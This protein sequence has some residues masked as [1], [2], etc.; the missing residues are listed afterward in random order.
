MTAQRT[1]PVATARDVRVKAREI[2]AGHRRAITWMLALH[3][4]A[5]LAA[6]VG[7]FLLGSIVQSVKDGTTTGH[8]DRL[9]E[10]LAV[11]LTAQTVFTFD[12][13]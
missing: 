5:A 12:C 7:P 11:S 13:L 6:V 8:V 1:L 9:A 3:A 2:F 4:L 10:L